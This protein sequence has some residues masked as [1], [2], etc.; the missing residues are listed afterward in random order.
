MTCAFI[1][2]AKFADLVWALTLFSDSENAKPAVTFF[3]YNRREGSLY[4][5]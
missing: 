5:W 4:K 3:S 2:K 1:C